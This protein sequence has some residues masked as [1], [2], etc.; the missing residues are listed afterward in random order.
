VDWAAPGTSLLWRFNLH[1]FHY[2]HLL[3]PAEQRALC[4][5]WVAA[6]PAGE[7]I[8]WHP[9]PTSLRLT[10]WCKARLSAPDLLESL[11]RQ[12]ASLYRTVE[13]HVYGNHVLENAR[14]LVLAG[15]YLRGQGEADRWL[16]RGL[17]L[18]RTES[19]EQ[20]LADGVH[21]ERSP[22]YHALMLEGYLDVLNVLPEEH[23]AFEDLHATAR[24]MRGALARM[25]RPDGTL[26]LFNDSTQEIAP[27]PS[28]IL[29][30]AQDVLGGSVS[31]PSSLTAS[32]YRVHQDDTAW[33]MVD[34]GAT[35]P[36]HLL[37]HAH[38]DT[39]SYELALDGT[40]FV[41]D[42]GVFEYAPG[43]MREYVRS[44]E[45]HNTVEVDGRD[46]MECWH[47]FRVARR[48][49]PQGVGWRREDGRA[50]FEGTLEGVPAQAGAS[51]VHQRRIEIRES[52]RQ[53]L[54]RDDI[55]GS[56]THAAKSR[57]HLH[58]AVRIR[59]DQDGFVLERDGVTCRVR[60]GE[61][62]LRCEVG[63]HCPRFGE[64]HRA[65]T[66]LLGKEE[67]LPITLSYQICY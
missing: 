22:M 51:V 49:S 30:Y 44:T 36:E 6:N 34:A 16:E 14:A 59:Q 40:P 43:P 20:I 24:T 46:Q 9:Y 52:Q 5:E 28:R 12:A 8:G 66:L 13:G 48:G 18:Y 37:A 32:G 38:S 31:G 29:Q 58:P 67:A 65:W 1:Y 63:W 64:R 39:F 61:G 57:I 21:Y 2:V 23:D 42:T 17:D 47:S 27:A 33:M 26:P 7:G 41:V 60:A 3:S 19:D 25:V 10:N 53:L 55:R 4:R 56:G 35:G 45:A 11:Y 62:N 54:V 15:L 50:V